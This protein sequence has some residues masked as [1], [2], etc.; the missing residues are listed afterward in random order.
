MGKKIEVDS[1]YLCV[2]TLKFFSK[3]E[4]SIC[5]ISS[6]VEIDIVENLVVY[7][8]GAYFH[9]KFNLYKVSV[10]FQ[11]VANIAVETFQ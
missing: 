10:L 1:V 3:Q 11:K 9:P 5:F 2:P 4:N 8:V 6:E 7:T